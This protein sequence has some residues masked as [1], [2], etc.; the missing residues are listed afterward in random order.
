MTGFPTID[1]SPSRIFFTFNRLTL[2][3]FVTVDR[4]AD[5]DIIEGTKNLV[6]ARGNVLGRNALVTDIIESIEA[7]SRSPGTYVSVIEIRKGPPF[8]AL[9]E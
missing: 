5:V 2:S 7:I 8:E 1:S 3:T 9:C 6:V 4:S